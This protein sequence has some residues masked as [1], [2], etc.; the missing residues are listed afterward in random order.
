MET[1]GHKSHT[2]SNEAFSLR[3]LQKDKV[4]PGE[5]V[6]L[7]PNCAQAGTGGPVGGGVESLGKDVGPDDA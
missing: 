3:A 5:S 4:L 2:Q 6:G 7:R 1:T